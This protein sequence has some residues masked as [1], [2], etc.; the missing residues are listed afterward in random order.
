[1][2]TGPTTGRAAQAY[3]RLRQAEADGTLPDVLAFYDSTP[4]ADGSGPWVLSQW[5][6]APFTVAGVEYATAEH[7][8]MAA[9]AGTFGDEEALARV[10][11]SPSPEVAKQAGRSVRGFDSAAWR[12]VAYDVVVE[13]NAHKFG[14]H[15]DLRNYL[16]G[17]GDAVLVEASPVD[18]VWGV[19]LPASDP[20]HRRPSAWLGEDLLGLA[21]MEVRDRLRG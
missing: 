15:E 13:G 20:A 1:M 4:L 7:W 9:K 10:L 17:T 16:V 8:M 11:A 21:L 19:G 2:T 12:A 5:W 6:P 3:A 18:R 14:A